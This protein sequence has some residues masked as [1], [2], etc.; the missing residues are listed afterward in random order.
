MR[1]ETKKQKP[2]LV[3]GEDKVSVL[4]S[5]FIFKPI[6]FCEFEVRGLGWLC[7]FLVLRGRAARSPQH[8]TSVTFESYSDPSL[9]DWES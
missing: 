2:H 1:L 6:F 5:D 3:S 8:V 9:G 7:H 4:F